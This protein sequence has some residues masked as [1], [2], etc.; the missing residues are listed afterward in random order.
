[1]VDVATS[2]LHDFDGDSDVDFS[3]YL[4]LSQ[5]YAEG[6]EGESLEDIENMMMDLMLS[7]E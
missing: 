4:I 3:D 2:T 7:L 1:M 6:G 5:H